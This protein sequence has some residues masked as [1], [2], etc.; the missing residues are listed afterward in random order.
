MIN[1]S[2]KHNPFTVET[3]FLVDGKQPNI[4]AFSEFSSQRFQ[5]WIERLFD[6]LNEHFNGAKD[7]SVEFQGIESDYLDL[8]AATEEAKAKGMNIHLA[9]FTQAE[10]A[11]TRLA[12]IQNLVDEA[13]EHPLLKDKI[14]ENPRVIEDLEAS[15]NKEFDIYVAATMSSGKSTLI[16]AMLGADLLPAA[17]EATTATIAKIYDTDMPIGEFVGQRFNF[18]HEC[19]D[20]AQPVTLETLQDWNKREDTLVIEIEGNVSGMAKRDEVRLVLSD[21]PGPN[22][23]QTDEHSNTTM[24]HMKDTKKNPLILYILN[25]TQ[26]GINDDKNTLQMI[27]EI[28]KSGGKQSK[29]RFI[30]VVNKMDMFDPEKGEDINNVLKNV[31]NYLENNGIENPNIYPVSANLTRL[32]RK[33]AVNPDS[34]SRSERNALRGMEELFNEEPTM[35]MLQYMNLTKTVKEKL[36]NGKY[37]LVE[38]RSGLPAVEKVID[39]YIEKYNLPERVFRAY[40]ALDN[41]I[42]EC[43]NEAELVKSLDISEK[44]S[45][46]L[47]KQIQQIEKVKSDSSKTGHY[48]QKLKKEGVPLPE[49]IVKQVNEIEMSINKKIR[50][51]SKSFTGS[52]DPLTAQ[53]KLNLMKDDVDFAYKNVT[54]SY[55]CILDNV[56]R[57]MKER[58]D[59]EY[60][61][62]VKGIFDK[63]EDSNS[64]KLPQLQHMRVQ[65]EKAFIKDLDDEE[66]DVEQVYSHT[67]K[68]QVGTK[69]VRVGTERVKTGTQR[70]KT[71][72]ERVKT[73]TKRVKVGERST[74]S[75]WNPFSW[76]D[77]ENI[78][79]DRDVFEERD[80][81]E[82]RDVFEERDV[83]E[84]R[85]VYEDK[86]VMK[87]VH[88]VNLAKL[89]EKRGKE[90]VIQFNQLTSAATKRVDEH[91]KQLVD[92]Y[93]GFMEEQFNPRVDAIINDLK[94][95]LEKQDELKAEIE[96]AKRN[97]NEIDAFKAK[98][99]HVIHL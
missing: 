94:G 2:I 56:D 21:T 82:N 19:V 90:I 26:L 59:R 71:G 29:D 48:I 67:E 68:V 47:Q 9:K 52:V 10:N 92:K 42:R 76:G 72:T 84:D 15:F 45:V 75:W 8:V 77:T 39:T 51:F 6:E 85:E 27:S 64:A 97:L 55:D 4:R 91:Q 61:E 1:I 23:S 22:N 33:Y 83:F 58:L 17:N 12:K 28:V 14:N 65:I 30:F 49:D 74:S 37:S 5:Q 69:K 57:E 62:Y 73:G 40:R 24:K 81:F 41:V 53:R 79:E 89:W 93:I 50:D 44:E 70:V 80:V 20:P 95:K 63:A 36:E 87:D 46:E 3:T 54:T 32:L 99:S 18:N 78:Y 88:K 31:R 66:I 38:K 35:D 86:A 98:V 25:A 13:I 96:K 34:L 16:N 11:D 43:S 60:Q 7:F